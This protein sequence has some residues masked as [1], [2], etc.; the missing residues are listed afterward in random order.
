[1]EDFCETLR[2]AEVLLIIPPF[3]T[4]DYPSL[5]AH[6]LQACGREAGFRVQVLYANTLLASVIGEK[7]YWKICSTSSKAFV[8]ERLFARCAFDLPPLGHNLERMFDPVWIPGSDEAAECELDLSSIDQGKPLDL[9]ELKR[10]ETRTANWID[11]LATAVSQRTY[12]VVGCSTMFQQTAAS[13]ALLNRIKHLRKDTVT[14]LG[15]AN[16][17]GEMARGIASLGAGIDY[18]FS[19]ES[20]AT[21]PA[22][23]RSILAGSHPNERLIYGQP[24]KNMD[25]L[26]TPVFSEFYEQRAHYLPNSK[27]AP[28]QTQ[29]LYETSR[30]CWWG[31]KRH[32]TFCGLNGEGMAFRQKSPNRVMEELHALVNAYP[33]RNISMTDNIMPYDYFKTLVPRLS[34]ELPGLNIFYEQKA[35]LSL[36]NVLA[37]RRAGI[38]SIQPGIEALSTHLLRKMRKGVLARQNLM[39]LRY[40]TAANLQLYWNH[41]WGFPGDK[42]ETY[43]EIRAMIPLLHH[44]QPPIGFGHVVIDRFSPYFF[45]PA[46][47]RVSNV[48]PLTAYYD[49][50]PSTADVPRIAYHFV[51]DYQCEVHDNVKVIYKLWLEVKRW[52]SA[53][54]RESSKPPELRVCRYRGWYVVADTRGLSGTKKAHLLDREEA[55]SLLTARPYTGSEQEVWAIQQKLALLVDNWFVPLAIAEPDMLLEFEAEQ[56]NQRGTLKSL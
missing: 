10:L 15:G 8:G 42:Q 36:E 43:E 52:Y 53:W 33:S 5:A 19:G 31:Q 16:C 4:L 9:S 45:Q 20:E 56:K 49:F 39:L 27:V 41:L 30:G 23:I 3:A 14:I 12:K 24:C 50:L 54:R 7:E 18:I 28:E 34:S 2:D 32:C 26:P 35:N 40:A 55:V 17:E 1:M 46:E 44:L 51:G 48:K 21:F 47:F 22:F 37:L 38:A 13:M 25:I 29:I 6:L 11:R